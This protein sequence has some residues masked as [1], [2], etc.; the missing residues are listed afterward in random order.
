MAQ[1]GSPNSWPKVPKGLSSVDKSKVGPNRLESP[2]LPRMAFGDAPEWLKDT[3][4]P[5]KYTLLRA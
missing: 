4:G 2:S 5:D 3:S 1:T